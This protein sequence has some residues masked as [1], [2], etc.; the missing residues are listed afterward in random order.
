MMFKLGSPNMSLYSPLISRMSTENTTAERLDIT[1]DDVKLSTSAKPM[2]P[3]F[4]KDFAR[5][6]HLKY[7]LQLNDRTDTFEYH[8]TEHLRMSGVYWGLMA[9]DLIGGLHLMP[10]E[11]IIDFVMKCY[12]PTT[13]GFAGNLHHDPHLL[14]TLSAIQILVLLDAVDRLDKEKVISYIGS[15]QRPNGSFTGDKFGEID[16]RFS[17]CAVNALSLLDALPALT[18]AD[19]AYL[20]AWRRGEPSS[21]PAPTY[22]PGQIN[23]ALTV[24]YVLSC[25]NFDGGFGAVSGGESHAGQIFCCL[26]TLAITEAL[27]FADNLGTLTWWLAARQLPCGGLNGRPEKLEDVCYRYVFSILS[28]YH[29]DIFPCRSFSSSLSPLDI[30]DCLYSLFSAYKHFITSLFLLLTP[31][32]WWVLSSLAAVDS[33]RYISAPD[34]IKF[35]KSAQDLVY[36]GISERPDHMTDAYHT[37][38]GL[39]GLSLLGCPGFER[40]D[41]VYALPERMISKLTAK[42]K[43]NNKK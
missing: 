23:V 6:N 34:L 36:G 28:C 27:S 32:S 13:G 29:E 42:W 31:R 7:I 5:V 35:I 18:E 22:N 19:R 15:L 16:T 2:D 39:A 37:Y 30:D 20:A 12:D 1:M 21:V 26:G 33:V 38:F 25:Q 43:A 4:E 9:I 24:R 41:P 17:Y 8:V 14:Y 3:E 11:K 10:R 40:I